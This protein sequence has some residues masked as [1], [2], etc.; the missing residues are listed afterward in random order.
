V[1]ADQED[2]VIL[3]DRDQII[4]HL[5]AEVHIEECEL[6][7]DPAERRVEEPDLDAQVVPVQTPYRTLR[8]LQPRLLAHSRRR[9]VMGQAL[10]HLFN[11]KN[12]FIVRAFWGVFTKFISQW[13]A[14]LWFL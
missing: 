13:F 7:Y 8:S 3:V 12:S 14:R 5:E 9:G 4:D 2:I 11:L 6:V 10:P 1:L